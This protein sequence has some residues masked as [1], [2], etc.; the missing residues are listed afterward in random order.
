M[1]TKKQQLLIMAGKRVFPIFLLVLLW[2]SLP[3][4]GVSA[5]SP[6]DY[7]D[8]A[9][10]PKTGL[11]GTWNRRVEEQEETEEPVP[12]GSKYN[13]VRQLTEEDILLMNHYDATLLYSDEG[14]LTF[15]RGKYYEE[16]VSNEEEGILSLNGMASLLGLSKG[17]EF[18]AV[19][20]ETNKSGY[21]IY[22][23]QQRYGDLTIENAVLK[24]IVGP[25]G[26]TAGLVNSFAPNVGIAP[27]D[28]SAITAAEAEESVS[29]V[30]SEDDLHFYPEYTRQTS[31]T[32][33]NVAYHAWAVFTDIPAS[34]SEEAA[35]SERPYLEHLVAY[36]GS[37]LMYMSV[38]NPRELV[39]GDNAQTEL[40]LSWFEGMQPD[41]WTGTVTRHDGSTKELSVPVVRDTEG[42]Y[43]LADLQRHILLSDYHT[44][45]FSHE[46]QPWT[47]PDNTGW[48]DR[49]LLTYDTMIRV[50]EFFDRHGM[51]S[52]D[53]FG[54]PILL[55][56]DYCYQMGNPEDNACFLGFTTGWALFAFSSLNDFGESVD[57]VAHKFTH[58]ITT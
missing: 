22:I 50:Y 7:G 33:A 29:Q 12:D 44:F 38:G 10:T 41:T 13:T 17:S 57:V 14:Y 55:L 9:S 16:K 32:I 45:A 27:E 25:D 51:T 34:V 54:A 5:Q 1:D 8:I 56:T 37:Y 21:T 47:S 31:V 40:A 36:D 48:P 26:Y 30:W 23:Y 19:F 6:D 49:Y 52:V 24:I 18:F 58:G 20:S 39:L 42:N 53:G 2:I 4:Y 46:Y 43:Y 28:E 11:A 15:L 35:G 3:V